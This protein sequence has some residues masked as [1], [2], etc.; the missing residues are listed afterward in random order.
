MPT[1]SSISTRAS[2]ARRA[3]PAARAAGPS[4]SIWSPTVKTG[5]SEVIGSWKII[6]MRAAADVAHL[7]LG[8]LARRSRPL[9]QD[10]ARRRCARAGSGTRPHDRQRGHALAAAG[11][12]DDAQH[13]ARRRDRSSRRRPPS[14]VALLGA[15]TRRSDCA[16]RAERL[17]AAP[18]Q[19]CDT[20]RRGSSTSR[21]P[22]P[23][24][25]RPSTVIASARPGISV[26][27]GASRMYWRPS[28]MMLPQVGVGGCGAE[29]EEAQHRLGQDGVG[30]D[31]GELH[32][33]RRQAVGQD[34]LAQDAPV[35]GARSPARP[36]RTPSRAPPAPRR[37]RC[38]R[39]AECRPRPAR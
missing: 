4:R 31:E 37:A 18:C 24:R 11:L 29:A 20:L 38:A 7:A 19:S 2:R 13:L 10:L 14:T 15:R 34:V 3:A 35:A 8:Q 9:E 27:Q 12:A 25:F 36:A 5:L 32:D 22:S 33:Q 28:A 16:R 26:I 1:L 39:C 6:E 21:R 30:E 23:S 17:G